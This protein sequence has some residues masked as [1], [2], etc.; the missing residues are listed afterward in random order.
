MMTTTEF[1]EK[2]NACR[3]GREWALSVA[4]DMAVVWDAQCDMFRQFV[5]PFKTDGAT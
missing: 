2:H 3:D 1:C 4:N 5:N